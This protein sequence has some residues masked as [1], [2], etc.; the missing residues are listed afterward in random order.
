MGAKR[1]SDLPLLIFDGACGTTLQTMH[2]P[3]SVWQGRDGCNEFLNLS[4]PSAIVELHR[5]FLEAGSHVVETNTFGA[6]RI[7]LAEYG[8]EDRVREINA[9]AV[10]HARKAMEGL[11]GRFVAGSVG[12]TTKLPSLGHI[13]RD[14]LFSATQEQIGALLEEG[15]DLLVFET[16]QDLLQLKSSLVAAFETFER[17]GRGVPVMASVTVE[18]TGTM[19]VGTDLAAA[20]VTLEPFPLFSLGL[21]CATGPVDME[22]HVRYLSQQ[23]PGRISCMPNQGMPEVVNGQTFYPLSPAEYAR[24]M[25]RFVEQ[26]GVSVVGGCC[27]TSPEHIRAL[28]AEL[29]DA[30]PAK[31]SVEA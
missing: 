8:L 28:A 4:A 7:V 27:G 15:V 12:P 3:H 29:R 13:S 2:V 26:Y 6:S 14:E 5:A 23:W 20:A 11:P 18:R 16:C 30:V 25:R 9:A 17:L 22:S 1:P 31:R 21:N 10:A 19:L 24:H